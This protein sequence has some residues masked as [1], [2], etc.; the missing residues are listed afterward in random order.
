[1]SMK[2]KKA[3]RKAKR[4]EAV[5]QETVQQAQDIVNNSKGVVEN[6]IQKGFQQAQQNVGGQVTAPTV[7]MAEQMP[8]E[9]TPNGTAVVEFKNKAKSDAIN[10][11][12]EK[13]VPE[14]KTGLDEYMASKGKEEQS[15]QQVVA[16]PKL[17]AWEQMMKERR[18]TL[19]K[20]QTD[21]HK[22]QQYYALT[23]AL[24][25]LGQMGGA[26]IGGAAGGD[27]LAG[28]IAPE[29]KASRGY[30]D[31]F[32]NAKTA[33]EALRKLDDSEFQ[34]RYNKEV[35]DEERAQQAERDRLG[36]EFQAQQAELNRQYQAQQ[37]QIA[38]DW[39]KAVAEMDFER[40]AALKKEIAQMEHDFK[41]KYQQNQLAHENALKKISE[42]IVK[43]Q[44]SGGGTTYT[45]GGGKVSGIPIAFKNGK[46]ITIPKP[47]YDNM[48]EFFIGEDLGNGKKVTKDNVKTFIKNNPDKV[49]AYLQIFGFDAN[50]ADEAAAETEEATT[51][52]VTPAVI[53]NG[54]PMY[55]SPTGYLGD[56]QFSVDAVNDVWG[57]YMVK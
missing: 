12:W 36:R 7:N 21:A 10:K 30:I 38:R 8:E 9:T 47:Y 32:E 45:S 46:G 4:E 22:M 27:V 11:L 54:F 53:N 34:L 19:K 37:A 39:N 6:D 24:K 35:R 13:A 41:L 29:Y 52:T 20:D 2:E 33:K 43:M 42:N 3:R 28:G 25:S 56:S 44:M 5:Y 16:E 17:S 26:A 1:M 49:G 23:D 14:V 50:L 55:F 48:Q 40:Q 31:A 51:E 18:E 15:Q 57:S